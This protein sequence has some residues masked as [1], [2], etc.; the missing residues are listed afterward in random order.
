MKEKIYKS[1]RFARR[2]AKNVLCSARKAKKTKKKQKK[3]KSHKKFGHFKKAQRQTANNW[4]EMGSNKRRAI[5]TVNVAVIA[6]AATSSPL[7]YL[8]P[9]NSLPATVALR[10]SGW[11][12]LSCSDCTPSLKFSLQRAS[13]KT[14]VKR[15]PAKAAIMTTKTTTSTTT[16]IIRD[17]C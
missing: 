7:Y 16:K 6:I 4:A 9:Q 11:A 13:L 3:T 10:L 15:Q 12:G 17:A 5:A 14:A 1:Q 8:W 2:Y